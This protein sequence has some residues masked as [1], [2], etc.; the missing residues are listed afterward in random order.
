MLKV[1]EFNIRVML[2][3]VDRQKRTNTT[4]LNLYSEVG[5]KSAA[6]VFSST[7]HDKLDIQKLGQQ[8]NSPEARWRHAAVTYTVDN[9]DFVL[10]SGGLIM[11]STVA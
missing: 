3:W 10:I 1:C 5:I 11:I 9:K 6:M 2:L 7:G 4:S 8:S